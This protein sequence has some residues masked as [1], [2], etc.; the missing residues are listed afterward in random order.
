[1]ISYKKN[2]ELNFSKGFLAFNY[3]RLPYSHQESRQRAE[4]EITYQYVF[5]FI[6]NVLSTIFISL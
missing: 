6:N 2:Y 3:F 1:M 4:L 5:V